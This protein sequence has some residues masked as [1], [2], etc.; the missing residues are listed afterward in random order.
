MKA[1]FEVDHRGMRA[2]HTGR[3]PW[4]LV[5][6]LV[7]NAWDE[8]TA[9]ECWVWLESK[10]PRKA[11]L[12][13][14]DDGVGFAK[15][16]DAWT[17]FGDTPKRRNPTVRGRFN[18]GEKEILC[19]ADSARI[20]TAGQEIRFPKSGGRIVKKAKEGI[21]RGTWVFCMLPWGPRQVEG[22]VER[23]E[24]LIPPKG[25]SFTINGKGVPYR[26]P[27]KVVKDTLET[28]L[29]ASM[30]DCMRATRRKTSIELYR[31]DGDGRGELFEM[32]I[33]VQAIECPYQVNVGQ[34]IPL[35]P[36]RDTVK[37]SYLQDVYRIVL[38]ATGDVKEPSA[39][40]I[41]RA[42]ED[43]EVSAQTVKMVM[44]ARYGG[45][46]ALWSSDTLAN[47]RALAAG[48][49]LVH[50]RT[51]SPAERGTM[52]ELGGLA[53]SSDKFS[54]TPGDAKYLAEEALTAGMREVRA[55]S[56]RLARELFG[57]KIRV[58]FY[59]M[60]NGYA[61]ASY[62]PGMPLSYDVSKLGRAWFD[63]QGP[64]H[65]AEQTGLILHE[66]G[67]EEGDGHDA[68]YREHVSRLA[69]KCVS[70]ALRK[71]ELFRKAVG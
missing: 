48:F 68:E 67:H 37:D 41:H 59:T 3:E 34:K 62:G 50:P 44:H 69:G 35:P 56:V 18:I 9:T 4:Q 71:P 17:F 20:I 29:Q 66:F 54:L 11:S 58:V 24:R 28:V 16:S 63:S 32:G 53:H 47:E 52:E 25:I 7:S 22:T 14:Y 65:G 70:L 61:A 6:E 30:N 27:F 51:L 23:L 31:A 42:V 15:I 43:P 8:P 21:G 40:W 57:H 38:E 13:V 60:R 5:K 39:T 49:T 64:Y 45:K 2:L 46:A 1:R 36:N 10:G 19:V 55:Y 26:E 12:E 33:P